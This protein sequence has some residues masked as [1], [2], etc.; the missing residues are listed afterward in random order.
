MCHLQNNYSQNSQSEFLERLNKFVI[1]ENLYGIQKLYENEKRLIP[2]KNPEKSSHFHNMTLALGHVR[3]IQGKNL[4]QKYH[5]SLVK[6]L[7]SIDSWGIYELR[8]FSNAM[9]I[10]DSPS[11]IPL[12]QTAIDRSKYYLKLPGYSDLLSTILSN[13]LELLIENHDLES[14][15]KLIIQTKD[16]LN[17]EEPT[18]S[19]IKI[20]FLETLIAEQQNSELIDPTSPETVIAACYSL[21]AIN[22]S[23]ALNQYLQ[24]WRKTHH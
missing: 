6:Y 19:K 21:K 16:S 1:N 9:F 12:A 13:A 18:Q 7:L 20:V 15:R 2:E 10:F 3:R 4:P 14:A 17:F 8:L 24:S 5:K 11:L 23:N 22:W